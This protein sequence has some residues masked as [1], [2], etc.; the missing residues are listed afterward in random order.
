MRKSLILL[1]IL[2]AMPLSAQWRRANL[3]GADVR[4]L[5]ID[6]ADPDKVY[7]GT[8]GGEVYVSADGARTW[9]NPRGSVPFPGYVVDNLVIDRAGRLWA[10]CW[11]LWGGGAIAVSKDGGANWERRDSGLEDES[12]RAIAVDPHD[13]NFLVAGAL[14]GVWRSTNA[15]HSWQRISDQINVEALAIDPRSRDRIY[16]GTWRQGYRTDDGGKTWKLINGGMVLDTDMF[17]IT[18]DRDNPDNIWV[19]TC[20]WVY[21]T[22][23]RGDNWTRFRDGFDNRRVHDIEIDPCDKDSLYAGTVAGLYRSHDHGKTWYVVS[24]E[25]L[26]VSSIALEPQRPDRIILGVEGDGVYVS[27]DK[28]KTFTRSCEGLRNLTITSVAADPV[29]KGRVYASVVFGGAS[30]GIYQSDDAGL[31]WKKLATTDVPQVLSLAVTEDNE[32]KFIA[33]TEKG[34]FWSRNGSEWTQATPSSAPIRVNKIVR[35][36][37]QRLFAATSEGVFT[38]RDSGKSWYRLAGSD[39][40]TVDIAVGMLGEKRAL[41]AL[42]SVGVMVFDGMQWAPIDGAPAKGRTLAIRGN[43]DAQVI[44]VAGVQ[45]VRAGEVDATRHWREADVP[46]AQFAAVFGEGSFVFL[47]SRQQREVLVAQPANGE[48]RAFPLPSRTAEV[49]AIALDPFDPRRLYCGT[50]GEGIFIFEGTPQKYEVKAAS[51]AVGAGSQ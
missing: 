51:A 31:T 17:E 33:G 41:F 23:N 18:V 45:G 30:S 50:L 27:D 42:T 8:S 14:N 39:N 29:A 25:S 13:A 12:I 48:W 35:Y 24:D 2:V 7:V 38:S 3:Y 20:G 37:K 5:L 34:F 15:G 49:T 36:T 19:A 40:R 28:G 1:V 22:N 21:G 4:A 43:G 6:P 44:F 46:D 16:V 26:V 9:R 32:M 10:A 11:G 47:T